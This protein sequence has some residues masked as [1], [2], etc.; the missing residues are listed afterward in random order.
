[1]RTFRKF[2]MAVCLVVVFLGVNLGIAYEQKPVQHCKG[3]VLLIGDGMGVNQVR[4]ADIYAKDVLGKDIVLNTIRT[5]GI[6]ATNS[7]VSHVTDSAAAATALYS[8]YKTDNR[9]LNV[10]PDCRKVFTIGHAAKEAGLSVG[11]VS[12]T[13][14]THA[15]P[16]GVFCHTPDRD[17]EN[18]IAE[19]LVEFEP[20]VAMAGG[21]RNFIPKDEMGSKR[22]DRDNLIQRM[23]EKGYRY[24]TDREGL[25]RIDPAS[26]KSLLGLFALSHMAYELDRLNVPKLKGQPTLA[27]MTEAAL[28]ILVNNP[29]GFFLMVEGGRIDHACHAHDIKASIYDTL[30]FDD[31]VRVALDFRKTHPEVLVLVTADH[32][33]GGLGLGRGAEY[34]IDLSGLKPIKN[35]LE[36]ISKQGHKNPTKLEEVVSAGGYGLTDA[37]KAFLARHPVSIQAHDVPELKGMAKVDEYMGTWLHYALSRIENE[38]GKI[39]WTS[40]AH[41]AQPVITYAAGPGEKE[42]EGFYDNTEIAKR[43]CK[44]LGV[45]PEQPAEFQAAA[46]CVKCVQGASR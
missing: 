9:R 1:M 27:D 30:A 31:A 15:T 36:Y 8:G 12:T 38:R 44:L 20:E 13:R 25:K 37:E 14:L 41:T 17:D 32:E 45:T 4:S 2:G 22:K 19:Q 33:T 5:R 46:S 7:A 3:I 6:T 29:K 42:F 34:A 21:R 28:S 11:I 35:S 24:V 40:V 39:G 18:C 16:A 26:T 23:K 43:M 10:L